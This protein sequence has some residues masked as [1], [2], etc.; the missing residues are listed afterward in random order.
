MTTLTTPTT[1]RR[2]DVDRLTRAALAGRSFPPVD[3]DGAFPGD[4]PAAAVEAAT[5]QAAAR[6]LERMPARFRGASLAGLDGGQHPAVL[7]AWVAHPDARTLL[8]AGPPGVGK[9]FTAAAVANELAVAWWRTVGVR[10]T[11]VLWWSVAGLLDALR[12]SSASHEEVWDRAKSVWVLVL[13]DLAHVRPTEWAIERLWLLVNARVESDTARTIVDTNA[14][15]TDL[16]EAWGPGTMDRLR[17]GA[18]S[19]VL[20]GPSRRRPLDLT[21]GAR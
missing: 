15:W 4:D 8:L 18:V 20:T 10:G 12:P 1:V 3:P 19:L 9:S 5:A 6:H 21:G 7:A 13:D 11:P 17:E 14:S 16:A 2:P